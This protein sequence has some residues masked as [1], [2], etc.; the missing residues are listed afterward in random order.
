MRKNNLKE[1][2]MKKRNVF[3]LMLMGIQCISASEDVRSEGQ[4]NAA[5]AA[6]WRTVAEWER[7]FGFGYSCPGHMVL[8]PA[9]M[10]LKER[11]EHLERIARINH[12]PQ[13]GRP[14]EEV[15]FAELANIPQVGSSADFEAAAQSNI[16]P[17]SLSSN[18]RP[19]PPPKPAFLSRMRQN[20]ARYGGGS[21]IYRQGPRH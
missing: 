3:V 10:D 17:I 8:T 14:E 13:T 7:D 15:G 4:V 12:G 9:I 16:L 2:M 21:S 20:R 5:K 6:S 1:N 11:V 18:Q 19:T